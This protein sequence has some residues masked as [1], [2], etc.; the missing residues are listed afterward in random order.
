MVISNLDKKQTYLSF[1]ND[2]ELTTEFS[3]CCEIQ[4]HKNNI[5]TGWWGVNSLI[6]L[7]DNQDIYDID[8]RYAWGKEIFKQHLFDHGWSEETLLDKQQKK[9]NS[10][11]KIIIYLCE[12]STGLQAAQKIVEVPS[13]FLIGCYWQ[14][15]YH[16]YI[17]L[18]RKLPFRLPKISDIDHP[19][20][21]FSTEYE[22]IPKKPNI[23]NSDSNYLKTEL[24]LLSRKK[25]NNEGGLRT[26]GLFK[27]SSKSLP[28]ISVITVV[29]NG[30]RY[31]EQTIQSIIN[32]SYKNLEYIIIDGGSTD[33]SIDI[34]KKYE[35]QIDYW[36]SEPDNGIYDAMNKGTIVASGDYTLHINA[37]DLLFDSS[38]LEKIISQIQ[39]Q[40]HQKL[41]N[42]FSS[43]LFYRIDKQKLAKKEPQEPQ[44][45]PTMNIIKVP[46][47]HQGFLGIRN[48]NSLFKSD[49]YRIVA[50][51]IVMSEKIKLE[52]T[53][54]SATIL[55]ICRSGGISYGINFGMLN[56][57][58]LATANSRNPQVFLALLTE[59]L[60]LSLL[61]FVKITGLIKL[62]QKISR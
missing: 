56:E 22:L 50:E 51:R 58:R 24:S 35:N 14:T 7:G 21:H 36:L 26:K 34:V 46:G 25:P 27:Y 61:W 5:M 4:A 12:S 1:L 54:I 30:E 11:H 60:R 3:T 45:D 44:A 38:C 13:H 16:C 8:L 2:L 19:I 29:F 48:K 55:A 15:I 33:C 47:C 62:K 18:P 32:S 52:P 43:I 39:N 20:N 42:L 17:L 31:L 37:D 59:Y 23:I 10:R 9:Q 28:L 49:L 53:I 41:S 6:C 57:M 40:Q